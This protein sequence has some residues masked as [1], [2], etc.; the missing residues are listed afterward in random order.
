LCIIAPEIVSTTEAWPEGGIAGVY[1]QYAGKYDVWF[2]VKDP[3]CVP[4]KYQS[5]V[6]CGN[7]FLQCISI[8]KQSPLFI[9]QDSGL[10]WAAMYSP[11]CRKIIY[12]S[13]KRIFETNMIFGDIDN[14][15]EDIII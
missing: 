3:K 7:T 14:T 5:K 12:H 1:E 6:L 2:M 13:K 15:Y 9:G 11:L 8:L 4:E 10:A